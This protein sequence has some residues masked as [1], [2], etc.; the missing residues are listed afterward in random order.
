MLVVTYSLWGDFNAQSHT[1][2]DYILDDD[3]TCIPG[4]DEW[5]V[6][7]G[8]HLPRRSR[9][10]N[11]ST[12]TLG[13]SLLDLWHVFRIHKLIGRFPG[14]HNSEYKFVARTGKSVVNYMLASSSLFNLV[15][16]FQ[17]DPKTEWILFSLIC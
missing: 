7:N 3:V 8:V 15:V 9:D 17:I 16:N 11:I 14:D 5:Y 6:V 13:R 1:D 4:V 12:N 10:N 2:K